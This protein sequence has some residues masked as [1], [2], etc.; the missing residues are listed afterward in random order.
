MQEHNKDKTAYAMRSLQAA[1]KWD[2]DTFGREY[3]AVCSKCFFSGCS[4]CLSFFRRAPSMSSCRV[5]CLDCLLPDSCWISRGLDVTMERLRNTW[6][7][8][9]KSD[10]GVSI[11]ALVHHCSDGEHSLLSLT[12]LVRTASSKASVAWNVGRNDV[13]P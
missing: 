10:L 13:F 1:M 8:C 6:S 4:R 5:N 12:P 2:E 9:W 11:T 3:G 7:C